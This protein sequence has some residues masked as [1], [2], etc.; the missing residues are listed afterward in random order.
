MPQPSALETV[1]LN[2]SW[3]QWTPE[4]IR[5]R[6]ASAPSHWAKTQRC[7]HRHVVTTTT[8]PRWAATV[9]NGPEPLCACMHMSRP[10]P[11][12]P[13]K[14]VLSNP[15]PSGPKVRRTSVNL[16]TRYTNKQI[17]RLTKAHVSTHRIWLQTRFALNRTPPSCLLPNMSQA[18]WWLNMRT[19]GMQRNSHSRR[20]TREVPGHGSAPACCNATER[21]T[22]DLD[23][24]N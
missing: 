23:P 20:G 18:M 13:Q 17:R 3:T 15:P 4:R 5:S 22:L 24:H 9:H 16:T 7:Q 12:L 21:D 6:G 11:T 2:T 10:K 14:E 1:L 8:S 19:F